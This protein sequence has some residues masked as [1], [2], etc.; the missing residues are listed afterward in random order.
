[1]HDELIPQAGSEFAKSY[2]QSLQT[3]DFITVREHLDPRVDSPSDE[4]LTEIANLFPQSNLID[5]ELVGSQVKVVDSH[6]HG[7]FTFEYQF[8]TGWALAN[9]VLE[10]T[11]NS[12]SVIGFNVYK[13]TASLKETNKFTLNNKSAVHY[14]MLACSIL[15][16]IFVLVTAF[17]CIRTPMPKRKWVWVIFILC[18]FGS[19][20]LNWSTGQVEFQL[21]SI[22]LF[23]ASALSAGPFAPWIVSVSL[24][25]GALM[26]WSRRREFIEKSKANQAVID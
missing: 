13:R 12:I 21:L 19:V 7:N 11:D 22:Y 16:P 25:L 4:K 26:F 3:R 20:A 14:L 9:A 8:S 18:G 6:W 17:I 15:I 10:K 24:P 1:M 2:L 5:T 23:A